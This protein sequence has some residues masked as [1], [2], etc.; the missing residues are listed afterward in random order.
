MIFSDQGG[1]FTDYTLV[2][3]FQEQETANL[4]AAPQAPYSNVVN[5]RHNG[6]LR[7]W[8][9]KLKA[10]HGKLQDFA[11]VL[12]EAVRV[13]NSTTRRHGW[14]ARYLAFGYPVGDDLMVR[15][16]QSHGAGDSAVR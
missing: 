5:E 8:L 14:A 15:V 7:V 12:R 11:Y 9:V 13:K 4:F 6:I 1:E 2:S 10:Q 16:K 3:F